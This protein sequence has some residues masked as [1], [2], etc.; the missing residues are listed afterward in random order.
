M[1]NEMTLREALEDACRL[2]RAAG[3]EMNGTATKRIL[4][5]LA[6]TQHDEDGAV[7]WQEPTGAMWSAGRDAFLKYAR[8]WHD[9]KT[10]ELASVIADIAPGS[11]YNAMHKV[12]THPAEKASAESV[13][14]P[15]CRMQGGICACTSGGSYGG[16]AIERGITHRSIDPRAAQPADHAKRA[17]RRLMDAEQFAEE[18]RQL[19]EAYPIAIWPE[20]TAAER[21]SMG[22]LLDRASAAMGRHFSETFKRAAN[23]IERGQQAGDALDA[24]RYRWMRDNQ[25][26]AENMICSG[27]P[28]DLDKAIDAAR[29]SAAKEAE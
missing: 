8:Q 7:D 9:A 11:I 4:A 22:V 1:A 5:A 26:K 18:L 15:A 12:A 23:L 25:S 3:Y 27:G 14:K 21:E 16:C 19:S 6:L 28:E 20:L 13:P 29:A 24:A 2:L 10:S 17:G